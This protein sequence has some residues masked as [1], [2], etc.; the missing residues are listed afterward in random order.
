MG[1]YKKELVSDWNFLPLGNSMP[2]KIDKESSQFVNINI[3]FF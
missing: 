2:Q 3:S 1:R